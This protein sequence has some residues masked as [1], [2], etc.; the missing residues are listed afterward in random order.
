MCHADLLHV[1]VQA[2]A[3]V[4]T[5]WAKEGTTPASIAAERDNA[6][7]MKVLLQAKADLGKATA[8]ARAQESLMARLLR[9]R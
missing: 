3:D 1:P 9:G 8:W 2:K 5:A 7:V 4:N 6:D